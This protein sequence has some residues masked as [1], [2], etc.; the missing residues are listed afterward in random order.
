[1]P[2]TIATDTFSIDVSNVNDQ[3][4]FIGPDQT[5]ALPDVLYIKR[6]SSR[7]NVGSPGYTKNHSTFVRGCAVG[8]YAPANNQIK[9]SASIQKG[10]PE[11]EIDVLIARTASWVASAEYRDTLVKQTLHADK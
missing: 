1:M 10:T 3:T 8:T 2:L 4:Q 11:A 6:E 7:A 5:L 9:V